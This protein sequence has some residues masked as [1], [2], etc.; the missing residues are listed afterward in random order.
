MDDGFV[1]LVIIVVA[2][3]IGFILGHMSGEDRRFGDIADAYRYILEELQ[4]HEVDYMYED[5]E[6]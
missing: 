4:G 2:V 6:E 5:A 1:N 3:F